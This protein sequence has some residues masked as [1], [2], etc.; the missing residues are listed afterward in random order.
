[1]NLICITPILEIDGLYDRLESMSDNL[2]YVPDIDRDTLKIMV[3]LFNI[4][5][6]FTNP[7][8]QNYML[9]EDLLQV[10]IGSLM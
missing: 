8:K 1:M 3:D 4:D 2:L 7:N 9:D 10:G 5:Y 6:I